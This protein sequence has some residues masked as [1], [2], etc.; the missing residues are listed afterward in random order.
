[1][2]NS[3]EPEVGMIVVDY[4]DLPGVITC[5]VGNMFQV[6]WVLDKDSTGGRKMVYMLPAFRSFSVCGRVEPDAQ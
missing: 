4:N 1:M 5:V 6:H 3:P 2:S